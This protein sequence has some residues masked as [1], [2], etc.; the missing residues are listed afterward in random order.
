MRSKCDDRVRKQYETKK[1]EI[2]RELEEFRRLGKEGS[3]EDLFAELAYCICTPQSYFENCQSALEEL[4]QKDLLY[5]WDEDVI[6]FYYNKNGVRFHHKK[7]SYTVQARA[8]LYDSGCPHEIKGLVLQ[9]L[10][11]SQQEAR[12]YLWRLNI[13]GLGMKET[14]HFLRNVGHGDDLAL[15]DSH[16]IDKLVECGVLTSCPS[17]S[18]I[19][20][21]YEIIENKMREWANDL[22]I[23]LGELDLLLWSNETGAM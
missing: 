22:G 7:A 11:L 8:R 23:S 6:A 14:S 10:S 18:E 21:S 15:L 1:S 16:I 2:H 13:R 20:G 9:L 4:R 5:S 17:N 12:D 19:S 3:R